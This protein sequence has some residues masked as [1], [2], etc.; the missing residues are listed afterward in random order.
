[1]T[2]NYEYTKRWN[3]NNPE[4]ASALRKRHR[5]AHFERV[6]FCSNHFCKW[7][8]EDVIKVLDYSLSARDLHVVLKRTVSS[9]EN[10]RQ[11]LKHRLTPLA[12]ISSELLK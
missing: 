1:M 2:K 3:K 6:V 4:K 8:Q 9:I 10:M 7:S 5:K 11:R 12:G